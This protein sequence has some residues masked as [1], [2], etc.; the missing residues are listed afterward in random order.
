MY[1]LYITYYDKDANLNL[2]FGKE[3][4]RRISVN[5]K[6]I[7]IYY[8][9]SMETVSFDKILKVELIDQTFDDEEWGIERG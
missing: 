9:N 4:V 8:K 3:N 1:N 6:E 5:N 7:S 2:I